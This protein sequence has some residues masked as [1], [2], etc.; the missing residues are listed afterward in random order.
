MKVFS[1]DPSDCC[2]SGGCADV[3]ETVLAGVEVAGGEDDVEAIAPSVLPSRSRAKEA[4]RW[5]K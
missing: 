5:G 1:F 3:S 4:L 2:S